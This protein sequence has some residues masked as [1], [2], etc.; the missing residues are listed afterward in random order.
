MDLGLDEA[1]NWVTPNFYRRYIGATANDDQ[2]VKHFAKIGFAEG[3]TPNPL[4]LGGYNP[5]KS[6]AAVKH[7]EMS[8]SNWIVNGRALGLRP[9]VWFDEEFYLEK[10]PDLQNWDGDLFTHFLKHGRTEGRIPSTEWKQMSEKFSLNGLDLFESLSYL[11]KQANRDIIAGHTLRKIITAIDFEY[12]LF[13][14]KCNGNVQKEHTNINLTATCNGRFGGS[15][16]FDKE[17]YLTELEKKKTSGE[18]AN[19]EIDGSYLPN[20]SGIFHWITTGIDLNIVPTYFFDMDYYGK[21]NPDLSSYKNGHLD[22]F[23]KYGARETYRRHHPDFDFRRYTRR[24][25]KQ[26][27]VSKSSIADYIIKAGSFAKAQDGSSRQ[28]FVG[29]FLLNEIQRTRKIIKI[30]KRFDSGALKKVLDFALEI[31]PAIALPSRIKTVNFAPLEPE[32]IELARVASAIRSRV[33]NRK[34]KHLILIPHC[35]L[36]G[37]SR[38]AGILT[39]MLTD[40][41]KPSECLVVLTDKPILEFPK[42]FPKNVDILNLAEMYEGLGTPSRVKILYD[43][44][45]GHR[46]ES[47]FNVNSLATWTLLKDYG[48][49]I[50]NETKVFCY[51]FCSDRNNEGTEVG[52]PIQ[53]LQEVIGSIDHVFCDSHYL[54]ESLSRRYSRS[55]MFTTIHTPADRYDDTIQ[56]NGRKTARKQPTIVWA[57]RLDPQKRIDI[58]VEIARELP[59]VNFDVWGAGVLSEGEIIGDIPKNISMRG[60]FTDMTLVNWNDYEALVYTSEWDG[61]PT[62]L[63]DMAAI[64]MPVVSNKVGGIGELLDDTCAFLVEP[65]DNVGMYVRQIKKLLKK[66]KLTSMKSL[67]LTATV[68]SKFTIRKGTESIRAAIQNVEEV[69][70][71]KMKNRGVNDVTNK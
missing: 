64:S 29:R 21:V 22:H 1:R 59:K 16:F 50:Q 36:S 58:L 11:S 19:S 25:E 15:P 32:K 42:W 10:Y 53:W 28:G 12:E 34:Y 7:P 33:K 3:L 4:F 37:A 41:Y 43:L 61:I 51:L 44:I 39:K 68:F 18:H 26:D 66:P 13:R 70:K 54:Q 46:V 52:Y 20:V 48:R 2:C 67:K 23:L 56:W 45:I 9:S 49:Q 65:F 8:F 5:T 40:I 63:L 35:R 69:R 6:N 31:D 27:Y 60:V 38:V 62:I 47:I 30:Q 57:G 14:Q 71:G 24:L 55:E 17:L